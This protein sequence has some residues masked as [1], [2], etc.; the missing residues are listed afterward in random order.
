[1]ICVVNFTVFSLIQEVFQNRQDPD[2]LTVK[3]AGKYPKQPTQSNKKSSLHKKGKVM[4]IF[5]TIMKHK[6]TGS[7]Y[8][9]VFQWTQEHDMYHIKGL[10]VFKGITE[11]TG[12]L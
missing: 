11:L 5:K 7:K 2:L 9:Q 12:N 3:Q 6:G 10:Q 1:M 8:S 4:V